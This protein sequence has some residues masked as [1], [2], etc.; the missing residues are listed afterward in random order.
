MNLFFRLT[1]N[2]S[3]SGKAT[4]PKGSLIRAELFVDA[5]GCEK[6]FFYMGNDERVL[7]EREVEIVKTASSFSCAYII[8]P[9]Q[10][11]S[12]DGLYFCHFEF[13]VN[14]VRY[15]TAFS[16][17]G[18]CYAERH[19]VNEAQFLIYDEQYEAPKWLFGGNM[20]QIF[21]DRFARGGKTERHSNTPYNDDWEN[22]IP[23]YP[24]VRGDSFP[25]NT[26]FGGSLYGVAERLDY[27]KSLGITVIYLNPIFEAYSNHKYDTADFL[28]VDR[29]FGG[30]AALQYLI[31][32]AHEYGM[33]IILDGVF[34]HVGNDSV[35]FDAYHKYGNGACVSKDS[36]YY[37]WFTFN[38][39]PKTYE[40]WWGITNLPRTVRCE[41]YVNFITESVIPKYMNMGVD[42]FRLDVADELESDF[43]DKITASVK[44]IKPDA[45]VIGEVWE[46]ASNKIAYGERKRYFRGRQLDSVTNYP[47]R[48]AIIDFVRY[49]NAE[50][51]VDTVNTLYR[52]YPPHKLASLMNFLGSHD[53]ERITTVLGGEPDMGEPNSELAI[54]RLSPEKREETKALLKQAYLLL[55]TL[56]GVPCIY[57]GDEIALEGYH[58][59]FNRRPFPESSFD[60]DFSS[61]FKKVNNIRLNEPL[62]SSDELSAE[63]LSQ[64]VVR[65]IRRKN[66]K[67]LITLANMSNQAY[68]INIPESYELLTEK[69][70]SGSVTVLPM[71]VRVF[72]TED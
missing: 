64:G 50:F 70:V 5:E 7:M 54:K 63:R 56:P 16:D 33:R 53:T 60:D 62:F 52:N 10:M 43:L 6:A 32:K 38:E 24:E 31:D 67:K 14:G 17:D 49:G 29:S 8:T 1:S 36:P 40:C 72:K 19:F 27:L 15:Y 46:D 47:F 35:Y 25:N 55:A 30:D 65:I 9:E 34:N 13:I 42:G 37:E 45:V 48:N 28:K 11:P 66:G 12:D 20:Y 68:H 57:Y 3:P 22:G 69:I 41:S 39:Y 44:A 58:D 51:L 61:F 23:E 26:H 21:P 59:P 18:A 71:Q 2:N 4:F